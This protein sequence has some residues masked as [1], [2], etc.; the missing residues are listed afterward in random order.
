[1]KSS[2]RGSSARQLTQR[3]EAD[4]GWLTLAPARESLLSSKEA[5]PLPLGI[6]FPLTGCQVPLGPCEGSTKSQPTG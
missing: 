1:M 3:K 5:E 6:S 2:L 4:A